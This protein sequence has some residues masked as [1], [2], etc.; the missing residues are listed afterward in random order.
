MPEMLAPT[1]AS[2]LRLAV[3][4]LNRRLRAQRVHAPVTLSQAS[5][6]STLHGRG[7]LTPGELAAAERV[8]PPTMTRLLAGLEEAGLLTRG[9]HPSDG[10]Q[11]LLELTDAGRAVIAAEVGARER[12]LERRLAELDAGERAVLDRA[13]AIIDRMA[14]A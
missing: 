14:G 6:L 12:W 9:P 3:V 1:L 11:C 4:R 10:R 7:P 5:A 13:A 2:R 8:Q